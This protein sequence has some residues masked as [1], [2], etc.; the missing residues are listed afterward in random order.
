MERLYHFA[1]QS[2]RH[3]L[4]RKGDFFPRR[5][6]GWEKNWT[7]AKNALVLRRFCI[8]IESEYQKA[9]GRYAH[10][11]DQHFFAGRGRPVHQPLFAAGLAQRVRRG[12]HDGADLL[13]DQVAHPHAGERRVQGHRR[14]AGVCLDIRYTAAQRPQ[15]AVAADHQHGASGAGDH[16]PAGVAPR[17]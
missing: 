6:P 13:R 16:V 10:G 7:F 14:G 8:I 5:A 12:G 4:F 9:G 1:R 3:A 15:L 2:A 17:P 11:A